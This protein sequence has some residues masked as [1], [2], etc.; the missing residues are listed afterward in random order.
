MFTILGAD[1]K[2]Y[3]PVS[4]AKI[5]EWIAGG[6]ANLQTQARRNGETDW[7]TLGDFVEFNPAATPPPL[8]AG[9]TDLV[10]PVSRSPVA[11]VPDQPELAERGTRLGA[12]LIDYLLSVLVTLPGFL[13]LGPA[14]FSVFVSAMRG[15][16]PD[17]SVLQAGTL[18]TGMAVL[19]LGGLTLLIVQVV[20]LS[21]RG[22]TIGKRMLGIRVVRYADGA[23]AGFVHGWLLRNLVPGIIQMVPWI[24]FAFYITDACFI[25]SQERRCLHDLIAGTKVVKV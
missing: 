12:F 24:G 3:G 7:K 1:G 25:F 8:P 18:L 10:A 6:R 20:M 5:A 15:Q 9:S 16:E 2:E 22:Q 19:V 17:F 14:F 23:Q 21:T 13:I 11:A 4:A